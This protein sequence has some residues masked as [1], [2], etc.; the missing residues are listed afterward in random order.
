MIISV[1]QCF[2][3]IKVSSK[4][5]FTS[6]ILFHNV[7]INTNICCNCFMPIRIE[8]TQYSYLTLYLLY[9][10]LYIYINSQI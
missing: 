1:K 4:R 10:H 9:K 7:L 6:K 5:D 3:L 8:N 2:K